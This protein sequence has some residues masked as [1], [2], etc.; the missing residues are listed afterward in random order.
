MNLKNILEDV[1]V[2]YARGIEN[3]DIKDISISTN[4]IKKDSLFICLKGQSYDGHKFKD[5]AIKKGVI[6]FVVEEYDNDCQVP[7]ILV[8]S[9]R[10]ALSYIS[11]N[12][13]KPKKMPKIIGITGTNGKTTTTFMLNSILKSAGKNVG[14]I[15]TEGIFFNG[16]KIVLNM[17]TPDPIEL[18]K[19]IKEM[20][21][22]G[23]EYVVMEVSAHA[24]YYNKINALDFYAKALTN[25][26]EDHLDFFETMDRYLQ[27]KIDYMNSGDCIKVVNIDDECGYRIYEEMKE[28]YTY[29]LYDGADIFAYDLSDDCS[30]YVVNLFNKQVE[31][32]TQVL[33]KYNVE[34]SLCAISL[35]TLLGVNDKYIKEGIES[36]TSVDGRMN[37]YK[38][39]NKLAIIDFAHT[40]DAIEK[41]LTTIRPFTKGKLICLFGCGGNRDAN[42]RS[43]MGN[44]S[45]RLSD[46]VYIT[47]DNPRFEDAGEIA[48]MIESGISQKNYTKIL[49]RKQAIESAILNM[50]DGDVLLLCGKGAENYMDIKGEKY[51]YS[52]KEELL[53]Y[54]FLPFKKSKK[55]LTATDES[56]KELGVNA[57]CEKI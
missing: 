1:K 36:F 40:P 44:I 6:A 30:S 54:G 13:Y 25:I 49:N 38:K 15:G 9:T 16:N 31:I 26:T 20:A 12:F 23:V 22:V 10:E 55:K 17:T 2:L 46:F 39:D 32:E 19:Y 50:C 34:N 35:A 51:P 4:D 5:E 52:D 33:G 7:Q 14:V 57:N 24:I 37:I 18:F 3:I 47:S 45:S 21:D 48:K 27:T 8:P 28:V 29:G 43:I 11:K 41:L 56:K 42:K 53:K